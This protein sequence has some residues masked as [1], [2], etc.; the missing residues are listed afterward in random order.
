MGMICR[1]WWFR[2]SQ[3]YVPSVGQSPK[4]Q[5]TRLECSPFLYV[6]CMPGT[7]TM[8]FSCP[9]FASEGPWQFFLLSLKVL[10]CEVWGSFF[11]TS[12]GVVV[13]S[14]KRQSRC[15]CRLS[16]RG[17]SRTS[18]QGCTWYGGQKPSSQPNSD[19]FQ[20]LCVL[21]FFVFFC[22]CIL[23]AIWVTIPPKKMHQ[24]KSRLVHLPSG[25]P[26]TQIRSQFNS[27]VYTPPSLQTIS[28]SHVTLAGQFQGTS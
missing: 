23:K 22:A 20:P 26:W 4:T 13:F 17:I 14:E 11:I 19:P 8:I 27:H 18:C 10:T 5:A 21:M 7:S 12:N 28:L 24:E 6:A 3:S 2:P 9:F 16:S 15:A 25:C 1:L